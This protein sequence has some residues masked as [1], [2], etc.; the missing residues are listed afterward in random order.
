MTRH[1]TIR[2]PIK[3]VRSESLDWD[4]DIMAKDQ[5]IGRFRKDRTGL[6]CWWVESVRCDVAK[7]F[8]TQNKAIEHILTRYIVEGFYRGKR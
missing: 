8:D 2:L 7:C 4:W 1:G 3:R 5:L 6:V